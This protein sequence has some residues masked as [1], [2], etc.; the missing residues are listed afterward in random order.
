MPPKK[1]SKK[2]TK[3][4]QKDTT[5]SQESFEPMEAP[6][7]IIQNPIQQF[8]NIGDNIQYSIDNTKEIILLVLPHIRSLTA[9]LSKI[10][11]QLSQI[12]YTLSVE[13]L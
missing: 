4:S 11:A 12:S 5:K 2:T 6:P 3:K 7:L 1:Q 9:L 10:A 8:E 13:H